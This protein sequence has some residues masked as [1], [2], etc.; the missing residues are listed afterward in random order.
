LI[1]TD[2]VLGKKTPE[3]LYHYTS[4]AG[5]KGIV[6]QQHIWATDIRFLNDFREFKHGLEVAKTFI[7]TY[8]KEKIGG[9]E[10]AEA[11][12]TLFSNW[13]LND[14]FT[15]KSA[16]ICVTSFS[17]NEDVLSQWRG[18]CPNGRGVCIGFRPS[19]F[20]RH[21]SNKT[22]STLTPCVYDSADQR[23]IVEKAISRLLDALGT[24]L[25]KNQTDGILNSYLEEFKTVTDDERKNTADRFL[26]NLQNLIV[27]R[28]N[29]ASLV[30][31]QS[32]FQVCALLK[33]N[34]FA[35]E[36][37]WRL[38]VPAF[39]TRKKF[40]DLEWHFRATNSMLIPYIPLTLLDFASSCLN[41]E[42]IIVGPSP[43]RDL[44][45]RSI[46][47]FLTAEGVYCNEVRPS[48]IP[49]KNW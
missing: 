37:E 6:E 36:K 28:I 26:T 10:G 27:N 43:D 25:H 21:I 32:L 22:M 49:Y 4:F 34:S 17:E 23:L 46:E 38:V 8:P 29:E 39:S 33:D 13:T 12:T 1:A 16:Q 20:N 41:F 31:A 19:T 3:V 2:E 18:Y 35:E 47:R 14:A 40:G 30:S 45:I 11:L 7:A 42:S 15:G 44:A 24:P 9:A 5:L 48:E